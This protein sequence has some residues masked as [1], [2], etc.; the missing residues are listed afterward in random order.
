MSE[1]WTPKFRRGDTFVFEFKRKVI[2]ANGAEFIPNITGFEYTLTMK[3]DF[4]DDQPELSGT[5]IP[6]DHVDD[7]PINGKVIF[8]IP[9]ELTSLM[10][11]G[12]YVWDIQEVNAN[13]D[14][15]TVL[16]EPEHYKEKAVVYP[17]VSGN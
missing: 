10:E 9:S 11:P 13:G 14:V 5:V 17:D 7:D 12:K 3:A 15:T 2:D 1:V 6:G 4:D 16:P 8:V